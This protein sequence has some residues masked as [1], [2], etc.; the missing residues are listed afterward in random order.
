MARRMDLI[1]MEPLLEAL[2]R[3]LI[4]ISLG[5]ATRFFPG[6]SPDM[7]GFFLTGFLQVIYIINFF[8]DFLFL[9]VAKINLMQEK[10]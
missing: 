6:C 10:N 5:T 9:L 3:H 8:Y 2:I 4:L 7:E 1:L